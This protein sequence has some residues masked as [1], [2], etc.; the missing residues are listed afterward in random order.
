MTKADS[1][2][3]ADRRWDDL[4]D[5]LAVYDVRYLTGG[6]TWDGRASPYHEQAGVPLQALILDLARAPQARLRDALVALLFRHPE[7]APVALDVAANLVSDARLRLIVRA[8][9]L[10]AA[11]LRRHWSFVVGIYLPGQPVIAADDVAGELGVPSPDLD[12]GRPC[13]TSVADLLRAGQPFP[14]A[15]E[16]GWHDVAEHVLEGL[17]TE[18]RERTA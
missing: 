17:R 12:Y 3:E 11:A 9:I 14:F 16:R 18:A 4:V 13:L 6:S 7:A 1:R 2:S 8:S 15:Y 10:A 5:R